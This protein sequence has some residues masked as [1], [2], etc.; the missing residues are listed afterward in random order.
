[1]FFERLT[2]HRDEILKSWCADILG[3]YPEEGALHLKRLGDPFANPIGT[4]VFE[5]TGPLF[6]SLAEG[7]DMGDRCDRGDVPVLLD[8]IIRPR[9]IQDLTPAQSV[10]FV[11]RLKDIVRS[12]LFDGDGFDGDSEFWEFSG[13][14]DEMGLVAF[15]VYVK[16]RES[17]FSIRL[18][19]ARS[20]SLKAFER[21]NEW[22][23]RKEQ[24]RT[25]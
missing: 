18:S 21:L 7:C 14:V 1:M 16:C 9:A 22:Q 24:R 5:V 2:P 3:C 23:T 6:D 17:V 20:R 11:Y 12:K 4:A 25:S 10:G 19:E 15:D 8:R 13:R